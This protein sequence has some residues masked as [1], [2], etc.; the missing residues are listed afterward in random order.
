VIDL[1]LYVCRTKCPEFEKTCSGTIP[2]MGPMGVCQKLGY[3]NKL[4]QF[5]MLNPE[6]SRDKGE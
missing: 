5:I 2:E 4:R 6:L 1:I 3:S